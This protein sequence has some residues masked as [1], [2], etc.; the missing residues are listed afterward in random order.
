MSEMG[1]ESRPTVPGM[2]LADTSIPEMS[3]EEYL[4]RYREYMK[5]VPEENVMMIS[6]CL[7]EIE[8]DLNAF[9][10]FVTASQLSKRQGSQ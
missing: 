9:N 8:D 7:I 1:P 5:S 3:S 2:E 4:A 10:D 6:G